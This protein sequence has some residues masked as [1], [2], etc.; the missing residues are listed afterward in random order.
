MKI[1]QIRKNLQ[2]QCDALDTVYGK[3][4]DIQDDIED[5][6]LCD[7]IDKICETIEEL[8]ENDFPD[9]LDYIDNELI[10]ENE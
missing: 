7:R 10:E 3:L 2:K 5:D 4:G 9:I 6:E 1:Q 8:I